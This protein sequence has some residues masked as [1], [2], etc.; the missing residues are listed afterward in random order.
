MNRS[1][2]SRSPSNPGVS[3]VSI[4]STRTPLWNMSR[5]AGGSDHTML[6]RS[7]DLAAR[8]MRSE[9]VPLLSMLLTLSSAASNALSMRTPVASLLAFLAVP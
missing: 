6:S 7:L 8:A 5:C 3:V 2:S 4:P 9:S 1:P